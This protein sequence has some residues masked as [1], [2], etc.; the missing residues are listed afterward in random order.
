MHRLITDILQVFVNA[1]HHIPKNRCR[2]L[3][4]TLMDTVGVEE[5]LWVL[6]MLNMES[7]VRCK[8]DPVARESDHELELVRQWAHVLCIRL[9][10]SAVI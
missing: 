4:V 5:Y 3:F 6:V 9:N 7:A 2:A 8:D 1:R 10:N